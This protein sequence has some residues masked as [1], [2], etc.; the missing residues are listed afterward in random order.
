MMVENYTS[1][2]KAQQPF[3]LQSLNRLHSVMTAQRKELGIGD[4]YGNH[5]G[6]II[7]PKEQDY[8]AKKIKNQSTRT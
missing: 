2:I 4:D 7:L 5:V 6:L 3:R 1:R 8:E